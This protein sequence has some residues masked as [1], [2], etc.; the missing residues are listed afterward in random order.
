MRELKLFKK[1]FVWTPLTV[2]AGIAACAIPF[3]WKE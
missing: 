2:P 3:E 1:S